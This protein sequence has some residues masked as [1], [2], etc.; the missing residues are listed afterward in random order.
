[1]CRKG[2]PRRLVV[3]T[4]PKVIV[5]LEAISERRAIEVRT[6]AHTRFSLSFSLSVSALSPLARRNEIKTSKISEPFYCPLN[7]MNYVIPKNN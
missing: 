2:F 4:A 6:L 5:D 1:M 3:R 7:E